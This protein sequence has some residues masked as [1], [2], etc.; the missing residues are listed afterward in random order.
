MNARLMCS[1]APARRRRNSPGS[2]KP[3]L[4]ENRTQTSIPRGLHV[5]AESI[6]HRRSAAHA[7]A[8]ARAALCGA[9]IGRLGG[10]LF[11]AFADSAQERW[12]LWRHRMPISRAPTRTGRTLRRATKCSRYSKGP[13]ATSRRTGIRRRPSTERS[14]RHG[15]TRW[16]T[17]M[18][19][20]KS[21][22]TRNAASP[23][24]RA[25]SSAG[26]ERSQAMGARRCTRYLHRDHV[27][28]HRRLP[29][30][31]HTARRQVEN[32]PKPRNKRSRGRRRGLS[33]RGQGDDLEIV[34]MVLR[35]IPAGP[36]RALAVARHDQ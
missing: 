4:G 16:C 9:R 27:A 6:P 3:R 18:A 31:H 23:C 33:E 36:L 30:R 17:P 29:L 11:H 12:S 8:D 26:A 2:L 14:C 10:P 24:S 15:T 7:R 35:G 34:A 5:P 22:T 28:R 21:S 13:N 32:E 1:P 20:P 25:Y 19:V